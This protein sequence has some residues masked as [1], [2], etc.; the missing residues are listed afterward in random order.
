MD[1]GIDGSQELGDAIGR[2][3]PR[4]DERVA[5]AETSRSEISRSRRIP[6]PIQT[7][8]T[9]G[10]SAMIFGAIARMSS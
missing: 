7:N 8:R 10:L 6:S 9:F 2:H 1:H 4:Q 5:D 3:Q